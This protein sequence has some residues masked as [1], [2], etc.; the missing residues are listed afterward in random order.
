MSSLTRRCN[1]ACAAGIIRA[2]ISSVPISRRKSAILRNFYSLKYYCAAQIQH[3]A[4]DFVNSIFARCG[5]F[6]CRKATKLNSRPCT[7]APNEK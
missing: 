6:D 1:S 5:L 2:G 7:P 3:R 4:A